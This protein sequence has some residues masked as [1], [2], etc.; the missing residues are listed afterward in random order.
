L[1]PGGRHLPIP[2]PARLIR[3]KN[4]IYGAHTYYEP[5]SHDLSFGTTPA[6]TK[7]VPDLRPSPVRTAAEDQANPGRVRCKKLELRFL[8]AF[9][10]RWNVTKSPVVHI[11][12]CCGKL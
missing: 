4:A 6:H 11:D 5:I 7:S 8:S 9:C 12:G 3:P 1:F 10:G 2:L